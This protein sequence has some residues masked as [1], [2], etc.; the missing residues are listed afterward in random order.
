M[1]RRKSLQLRNT[2]PRDTITRSYMSRRSLLLSS[3]ALSK[4][5]HRLQFPEIGEETT[6][7]DALV[8]QRLH[9]WVL[10]GL[11]R[12]CVESNA[13]SRKYAQHL[14]DACRELDGGTCCEVNDVSLT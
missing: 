4:R 10:F 2:P 11:L 9:V 7:N 5:L 13:L 12:D 14:V 8:R 3:D 6:D 1:L